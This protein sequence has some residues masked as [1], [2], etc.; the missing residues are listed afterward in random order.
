M[1]TYVEGI[2]KI[3]EAGGKVLVGNEVMDKNGGNFVKPTIC[4]VE[5]TNPMIMEELFVP[6]LYVMKFKTFDEAIEM[7]N[8]VP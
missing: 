7:N 3:V 6:I 4:E 2:K 5:P 8:S 1:N